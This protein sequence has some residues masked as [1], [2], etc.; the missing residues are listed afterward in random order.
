MKSHFKDKHVWPVLLHM[1]VIYSFFPAFKTKQKPEVLHL[2]PKS[3]SSLTPMSFQYRFVSTR[4][5]F[6]A[7]RLCVK[8]DRQYY[9]C[10]SVSTTSRV[11][12]SYAFQ[13][14]LKPPFWKTTEEVRAMHYCLS[15]Q[16]TLA[17]SSNSFL[18][19]AEEINARRMCHL[20][21]C[22]KNK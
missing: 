10:C 9:S 6:F 5:C 1:I 19:S 11:F 15:F 13:K 22:L 17:I 14:H 20:C 16:I 12:N 7:K 3:L 21:H 2:W 4:I 8:F 18:V